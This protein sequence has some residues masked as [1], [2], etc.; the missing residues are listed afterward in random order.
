MIAAGGTALIVGV[1]FGD[2]SG[3]LVATLGNSMLNAA[4]SRDAE[5]QADDFAAKTMTTLGRPS[6]PMGELLLRITGA[7]KDSPTLLT[8]LRDHPMSEDR[9]AKLAAADKGAKQ[10]PLLTD[11]EWKALRGICD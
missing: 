4:H 5:A 2:I 10:A 6:K 3:G 11:E 9:L 7:E 1:M 8:I